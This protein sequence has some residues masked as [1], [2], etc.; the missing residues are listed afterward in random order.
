MTSAADIEVGPPANNFEEA[1]AVVP[2]TLAEPPTMVMSPP[3]TPDLSLI[4]QSIPSR[5]PAPGSPELTNLPTPKADIT[6][7]LPQP[8][9]GSLGP[10]SVGDP[11]VPLLSS[12][13][14]DLSKSLLLQMSAALQHI[15]DRLDCLDSRQQE[16]DRIAEEDHMM[17]EAEIADAEYS[18]HVTFDKTTNSW[19]GPNDPV[20]LPPAP[21][22]CGDM[23][24]GCMGDQPDADNGTLPSIDLNMMTTGDL[25]TDEEASRQLQHFTMA[26]Q[27]AFMCMNC[28]PLNKPFPHARV[29]EL[30]CFEDDYHSFCN[31]RLL[32]PNI[33]FDEDAFGAFARY[34]RRLEATCKT[35]FG[36]I[37][38]GTTYA[39]TR[40]I[41]RQSARASEAASNP[42]T[43]PYNEP[44]TAP[45]PA[46]PPSPGA[47][48]QVGKK[49]KVSYAAVTSTSG[50]QRPKPALSAPPPLAPKAVPTPFMQILTKDQ[51]ST[52]S[53]AQ[54][55]ASISM[56]FGPAG[57]ASRASGNTKDN[58]IRHYMSLANQ[59]HQVQTPRHSGP[60][61][62]AGVTAWSTA[63]RS[64]TPAAPSTSEFT[65]VCGPSAANPH[66]PRRDAGA[67]VRELQRAILQAPGAGSPPRIQLLSG[68]WSSQLSSNFVFTFAG[69]PSNETVRQFRYILLS[70]FPS[71]YSLV[72]QH[73]YTRVLLNSVPVIRQNGALPSS[74]DLTREL[75]CNIAYQD[76][77]CIA[78]PRWLMAVIPEGKSHSSVTFAFIDEDGS[79]ISWMLRQPPSLFGEVVKAKRFESLPVIRQCSCCHALGHSDVCCR[80][81][82][83]TIVCPVCSGRHAAA[84]HA[85]KCPQQACH[86]T[87][88]CDCPRACFNCRKAGLKAVGH[89][90]TDL[91]CPL[92]KKFRS[93]TIRGNNPMDSESRSNPRMAVDTTPTSPPPPPNSEPSVAEV[94]KPVASPHP[95]SPE[96]GVPMLSV[97]QL[98]SMTCSQLDA[99]NATQARFTAGST[100]VTPNPH[101]P[102]L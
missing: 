3:H 74:A 86:L 81:P 28:L 41:T 59:K 29:Q 36:S 73:G 9:E 26:V 101:M 24:Q 30:E 34:F 17:S 40:S 13:F 22:P 64:N 31:A 84:D 5:T 83:G 51:L 42:V 14:A 8:S 60:T 1:M 72:P 89:I 35:A 94:E 11:A 50:G 39:G 67:I 49:G 76:I 78:P 4:T 98:A 45:A 82:K 87:L 68:R 33:P 102:S 37:H 99:F 38:L 2:D 27:D 47:W 44:P 95:N 56:H 63:D 7:R 91:S 79:R 52:L 75:A 20:A 80:L 62:Q 53:K 19:I 90:S 32:D 46:R 88:P 66:A 70:P 97:A 43:L 23:S 71:G 18:H 12:M 58:L 100:F 6:F 93:P 77:L 92:R 65:A 25:Q 57:R 55:A 48:A 69:T 85:F 96:A 15:H 54:I 21:T 61:S 10:S 16:F